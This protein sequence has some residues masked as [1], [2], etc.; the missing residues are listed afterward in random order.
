MP[1]VEGNSNLLLLRVPSLH[2][3][4]MLS[5]PSLHKAPVLRVP[6]LDK[7]TMPNKAPQLP[8]AVTGG[9]GAGAV[10][11]SKGGIGTTIGLNKA[12]GEPNKEGG[13]QHLLLDP[14]TQTGILKGAGGPK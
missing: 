10:G 12:N 7:A 11:G 9:M 6:S 13:L 3:A 4:I 1:G 14:P 8:V 2:K 5:V